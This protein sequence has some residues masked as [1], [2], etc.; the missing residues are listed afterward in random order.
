MKA[1]YKIQ[2]VSRAAKELKECPTA[3]IRRIID[4]IEA[5]SQNPR[6]TNSIK[7]KGNTENIWRIR[8]DD[9]RVIYHIEDGI[10]IVT[11]R[12]I[13]HRKDAYSL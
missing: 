8:I 12:H 5:L 9:Y 13:R 6:P 2:F 1:G 3:Q 4:Q 11:I 10:R 7:L